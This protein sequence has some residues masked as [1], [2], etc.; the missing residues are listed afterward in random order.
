[1]IDYELKHQ[2]RSWASLLSGAING[3]LYKALDG[4]KP[5]RLWFEEL[6]DTLEGVARRVRRYA[7]EG[8]DG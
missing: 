5:S 4:E 6:A 7:K 8:N 2:M 3:I 1:M